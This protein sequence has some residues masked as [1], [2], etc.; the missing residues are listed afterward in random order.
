MRIAKKRNAWHP[1]ACHDFKQFRSIVLLPQPTHHDC[2]SVS[3]VMAYCSVHCIARCTMCMSNPGFPSPSTTG[4][5]GPSASN[6]SN[7][8][9]AYNGQPAMQYPGHQPDAPVSALQLPS[10]A[11]PSF[12][13][14]RHMSTVQGTPHSYPNAVQYSDP[15]YVGHELSQHQSS[16]HRSSMSA[17][18]SPYTH[19]IGGVYG[20]IFSG[21]NQPS[22]THGIASSAADGNSQFRV[23]RVRCSD[24]GSSRNGSYTPGLVIG[25]EQEAQAHNAEQAKAQALNQA[26][27]KLQPD[28]LSINTTANA[29]QN[30]D[31]VSSVP[32]GSRNG[33]NDALV[34]LFSQPPLLASQD[35]VQ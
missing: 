25:P 7:A 5:R 20:A 18:P 31:Q 33:G 11:Q 29:A 21:V 4:Q 30:D 35:A 16:A 15:T 10:F 3:F 2:Y 12:E 28:R 1:D 9:R 6:G 32:S 8:S 22:Q 17:F 13:T 23:S 34:N 26:M 27:Y 24:Q 14:Q 19:Q